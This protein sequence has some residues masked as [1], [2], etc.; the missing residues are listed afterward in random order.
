M[1]PSFSYTSKPVSITLHLCS[2]PRAYTLQQLPLLLL[3]SSILLLT[4]SLML[5][6]WLLTIAK[7]LSFLASTAS[8]AYLSYASLQP[9]SPSPSSPPTIF[10]S[11]YAAPGGHKSCISWQVDPAEQE[12]IDRLQS[13]APHPP[14]SSEQRLTTLLEQDDED[15]APA[16]RKP[17]E[18]HKERVEDT[19][20]R[21]ATEE[22]ARK[23]TAYQRV[24]AELLHTEQTYTKSLQSAVDCYLLPL[25]QRVNSGELKLT[26]Q[27]ASTL[28]S[29][30][31][32]ILSFHLLLQ[33]DLASTPADHVG[34][35]FL[36]YADY[37]KMYTVY[38]SN[39]SQC[40]ALVSKLSMQKDFA[41]FLSTQRN[42]RNSG[43]L[44]LMSYLIQPI[45]RIPRYEMLLTQLVKFAPYASAGQSLSSA[46]TKIH[47]IAL[48][49]NERKREAENASFILE[50]QH[51]MKGR[52]VKESLLQ[53][54]RKLVRV[55]EV[56]MARMEGEGK[57]AKRGKAKQVV[58][59]LLTD[60]LVMCKEDYEW[61]EEVRARDVVRVEDAEGKAVG[62]VWK[63]K[64]GKGKEVSAVVELADE[65]GKQSWLCSLRQYQ[66]SA[67]K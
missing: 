21:E 19:R 57:K 38:V 44:D 31:S 15:D 47:G 43:G 37:L 3:L 39:Y 32:A 63:E 53:P 29:N 20:A 5:P 17:R 52:E 67:S 50:I 8:L 36:K 46:L 30:L 33:A 60:L 35:V 55:G 1:S 26:T 14:S 66:Q 9:S 42:G 4:L 28:F 16:P 25:Q 18:E 54:S 23:A 10:P 12:R 51:R 65:E 13:A 61:R 2:P 40:L 62:V 58:W 7:H 41:R 45:Q 48:L 56:L 49:V 6:P 59:V 64:D 27:D 22:K 11:Y 34:E 24:H